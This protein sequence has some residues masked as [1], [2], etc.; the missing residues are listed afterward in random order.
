MRLICGWCG[1]V[2]RDGELPPSHGICLVCLREL[3][4]E[5]GVIGA[6][7]MLDWMEANDPNWENET[8]GI[9]GEG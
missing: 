3:M 7:N 8:V 5:E 6:E 4:Q 2:M 9:G 1:L